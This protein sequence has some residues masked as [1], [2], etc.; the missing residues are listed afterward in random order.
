MK[1]EIK[2]VCAFPGSNITSH[3]LCL[4]QINRALAS[5]VRTIF[6]AYQLAEQILPNLIWDDYVLPTMFCRN[7]I[8][9]L[10]MTLKANEIL[11]WFFFL[12]EDKM[13]FVRPACR[14]AAPDPR[15]LLTMAIFKGV[16]SL[17][18]IC[19]GTARLG[20]S[21]GLPECDVPSVTIEG[22]RAL[23]DLIKDSGPGRWG[24]WYT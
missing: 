8:L 11:W 1:V 14:R 7:R 17:T 23:Q 3:Q 22:L 19:P 10:N 13:V 18:Q 21:L 12:K 6:P 2:R 15:G 24:R 16:K 4:A 20:G 9:R 5:A